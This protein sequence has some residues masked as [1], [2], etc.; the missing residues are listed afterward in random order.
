MATLPLPVFTVEEYLGYETGSYDSGLP[1]K[2]EF[3][4]GSILAMAGAG[5]AHNVIV[6]NIAAGIHRNPA[7]CLVVTSD[8][9]VRVEHATTWVYPDVAAVCGKPDILDTRPQT[10][11]NPTLLVEVLSPSTSAYDR[12]LKAPRY[13]ACDSVREV[14]LVDP[15]A[16]QLELWVR[17]GEAGWRVETITDPGAVLRLAT[18]GVEIPVAEIYAGS[19]QA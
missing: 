2:H 6:L 15:R 10:L 19:E 1:H 16:V 7:G 18:V 12:N 3:I 8:M 11:L 17:D 13:R 14:L 9:R 5:L 4:D